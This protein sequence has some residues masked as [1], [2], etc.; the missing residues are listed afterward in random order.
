MSSLRTP[1]P[2]ASRQLRAERRAFAD[3][4]RETWDR[5]AA[6]NPWATPF[7]TWAFQRA[8]WDAYGESAHEETLVIVDRSEERRVG[9]ECRL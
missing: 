3:I 1:E 4:P 9:K 8:W 6:L 7:S 2:Q 5:L